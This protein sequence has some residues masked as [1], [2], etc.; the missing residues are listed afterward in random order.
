MSMSINSFLGLGCID[1]DADLV[2]VVLAAIIRER[3]EGKYFDEEPGWA[4]EIWE[5]HWAGLV[6]QKTRDIYSRT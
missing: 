1:I 5:H 3:K 6:S 4:S 2:N